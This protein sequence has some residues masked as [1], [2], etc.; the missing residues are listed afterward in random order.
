MYKSS[1]KLERN[2]HRVQLYKMIIYIALQILISQR[3][4]LDAHKNLISELSLS[5]FLSLNYITMK[6]N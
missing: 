4:T 6:I 3:C 5:L 1:F 2:V